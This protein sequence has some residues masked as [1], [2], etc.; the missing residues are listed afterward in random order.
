MISDLDESIKKLVLT[1]GELAPSQIDVEFKAPDREW[2]ASIS[3]PTVNIYLYDIRENHQ[4]RGTEWVINRNDDGTATRK[5]N[6]SRIDIS[7]LITVW[8]NDISDEHRLLWHVMSTLFR[9][10]EMPE[11]VLYG[12][13]VEHIYP[14]K[15]STAQP[16]GLFNN[17]SDFWAALDNKIKASI[18]YVVTVPLDTEKAFTAPTVKTKIIEVKPPE[19]DTERIIQ[20]GGLVQEGGKPVKGLSDAKVLAKEAGM[21]ARIDAEGYYTFPNIKVGKQTFKI[22]AAG[23]ELKETVVTIP[24]DNYDLEIK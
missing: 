23:K 22:I 20:I 5:K 19:T 7:Y 9:Y 18:N 3:K 16:D 6:P 2:S 21:T 11:D 8:A 1:K 13:L 10:P 14:I 24:S 12:E 4:L 15:T 17:P